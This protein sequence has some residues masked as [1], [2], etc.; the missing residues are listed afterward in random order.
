[1][2]RVSSLTFCLLFLTHNVQALEIRQD[3][4]CRDVGIDTQAFRHWKHLNTSDPKNLRNRYSDPP[5][6]TSTIEV[7]LDVP[8]YAIVHFDYRADMIWQRTNPSKYQ[9]QGHDRAYHSNNGTIRF[10]VKHD[11]LYR[12]TGIQFSNI[13]CDIAFIPEEERCPPPEEGPKDALP[14]SLEPGPD[15]GGELTP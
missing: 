1:M 9:L 5:P 15:E 14:D 10:P 8:P 11:H 6:V 4:N 2:A 13:T 3:V 12:I 7:P